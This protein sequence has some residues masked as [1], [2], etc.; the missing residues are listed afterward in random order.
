MLFLYAWKSKHNIAADA[1]NINAA[2]GSGSV[3]ESTI[4]C[5]HAKFENGDDS[6][7]NEDRGR[8]ETYGQ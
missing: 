6:L 4:Q 1:Q 3:N 5:G 8:P 2:F 7:T